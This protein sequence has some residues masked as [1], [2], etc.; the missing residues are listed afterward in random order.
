MR[1][2]ERQ[3]GKGKLVLSYRVECRKAETGI[4]KRKLKRNPPTTR[5]RVSNGYS[6]SGRL[7]SLDSELLLIHYYLN[8]IGSGSGSESHSLP[9]ADIDLLHI[10]LDAA[11][12]SISAVAANTLPGILVL[13]DL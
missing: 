3:R 7:E 10:D 11:G 12:G 13:L 4:E 5:Q 8:I 9:I 6:F 1:T 2:P